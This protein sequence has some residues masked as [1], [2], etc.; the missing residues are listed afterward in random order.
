MVQAP[1]VKVLLDSNTNPNAQIILQCLET[2][3]KNKIQQVPLKA[4]SGPLG[5]QEVKVPR[6][7][8]NGTGWW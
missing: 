3:G 1:F 6:F 4:W 7:H 5:F 8:H 2:R